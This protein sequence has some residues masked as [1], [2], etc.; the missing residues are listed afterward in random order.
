[1]DGMEGL[2]RTQQTDP[3]IDLAGLGQRSCWL[4]MSAQDFSPPL[5]AMDATRQ[6]MGIPLEYPPRPALSKHENP[7]FPPF[8]EPPFSNVQ[9]VSPLCVGGGGEMHVRLGP[10]HHS[11][12][13]RSCD[14]C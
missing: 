2:T 9:N 6:S 5:C 10:G 13:R 11:V 7:V 14:G 3:G 8:L 4:P 1:M 12:V